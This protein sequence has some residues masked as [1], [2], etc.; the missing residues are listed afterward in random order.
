MIKTS[1]IPI[2]EVQEVV[3]ESQS[4]SVIVAGH[5]SLQTPEIQILSWSSGSPVTQG[6]YFLKL[7]YFDVKESA[8]SKDF[9]V[10]T[11]IT[12]CIPFDASANTLKQEIER[13]QFKGS[14]AKIL[15]T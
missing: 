13:K 15:Y 7:N 2:P 1:S 5:F 3:I 12:R 4:K 9:V 14:L 6:S 11:L 8:G 10:K